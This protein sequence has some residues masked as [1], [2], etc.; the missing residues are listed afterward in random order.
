MIKNKRKVLIVDGTVILNKSNI[1][2]VYQS[3]VDTKVVI[4]MNN[5]SNYYIDS[6]TEEEQQKVFEKL[7]R[8]LN[9]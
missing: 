2:Q 7:I 1:S 9:H 5:E 8:Y 6:A 3:V 4:H